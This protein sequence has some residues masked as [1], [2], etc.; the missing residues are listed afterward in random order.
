MRY[1]FFTN[2]ERAWKAM[3]KSISDAK[4]SVYLE[5]YIFIDNM[6]KYDFLTLLKEKAKNG[7]R[8][9]VVL[10]A[11]GSADIRSNAV[12]EL[13]ESGAEVFFV[14]NLIY[15]HHRK[16]LVVDER[17]AFIGGVNMSQEFRFWKDLVVK[18]AGP[19]IVR[20]IIRSF[21]E[22]YAEAGGGDQKILSQNKSVVLDKSGTWLVEHFPKKKKYILKRLY[23]DH[24]RK[25]KEKIILVA[26]YFMPKH[27]LIR[28]L[29]EAVGRGVTVEVLVPRST[30]AFI[31]DRVNYFYISR[32]SKM[33]VHFYILPEI[34]HAKV[35]LIDSKEGIVGSQNLDF[36]SFDL[37]NEIGV[38][39]KDHAAIK[40]LSEIVAK[41]KKGAIFFELKK[42]KPRWFDYVLSPAISVFFKVLSKTL[43]FF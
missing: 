42:Y 24:I 23:K 17:E 34:N 39:L 27:W 5:M 41:W 20:H 26:P 16:V 6:E 19:K 37:N 9:R 3:Y 32:L 31:F 15:H 14:S 28:E 21:A 40:R 13:R 38:F 4:E 11:L 36:L 30:D 8:V 2:S 35:M 22:V 1:Q 33:G 12:I 25:A 7:L 43:E 10:D 29:H 18:V